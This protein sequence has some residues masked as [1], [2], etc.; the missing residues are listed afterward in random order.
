MQLLNQA[1]LSQ[2]LRIATT[3]QTGDPADVGTIHAID[4]P[5]G[6]HTVL[7]EPAP[8]DDRWPGQYL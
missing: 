4:I 5:D 3:S 8:A 6:L 2:A 1:T 7:P